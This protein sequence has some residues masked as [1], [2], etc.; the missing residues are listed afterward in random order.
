MR[1]ALHFYLHE[2][3]LSAIPRSILSLVS[4]FLIQSKNG[5]KYENLQLS[6]RVHR[7]FVKYA[8]YTAG[9]YLNCRKCLRGPHRTS[10]NLYC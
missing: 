1:F 8:W 4:T 5:L 3:K 10:S 7:T 6:R 9:R 2:Y